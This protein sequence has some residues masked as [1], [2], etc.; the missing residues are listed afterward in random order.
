MK[1]YTTE[2]IRNVA[3]VGHS[4]SGKTTL[5]EAMMFER[6]HIERMGRTEDGNTQSDFLPEEIRRGISIS[7]AILP[8]ETGNVKIN[9]LDLP[10]FRD[11]VGEIKGGMRVSGGAVVVV[12]AMGGVEVGTEFALDYA[13]EMEVP[14]IFFVNKLDKDNSD[15]D[16]AMA[17][18]EAAVS[19]RFIVMSFPIGVA[20]GVNGVVDV[21][22][23]KAVYEKDGKVTFEDI[24]AGLRDRAKQY[25][26]AIADQAASDDDALAEK[27][28]S[29]E[30]LSHEEII[31]GL[32]KGF[33]ERHYFP[34][35]AGVASQAIG[36]QSLMDFIETGFPNPTE[37][38]G[39]VME[40]RETHDAHEEHFSDEGHTIIYVFKTLSDK[41][42]DHNFFK[43]VSGVVKKDVVLRNMTTNRDERLGHIYVQRGKSHEE[44]AELHAG[45]LGAVTKLADVHTNDTLVSAGCRDIV[46]PIRYPRPTVTMAIYPENRGDEDRMGEAARKLIGHDPTLSMERDVVTHETLV[47]GMGDMHLD[48]LVSRLVNNSKIPCHLQIPR[49]PYKE[50]VTARA[51]GAYRHKKQSGGRGQFGEVHLRVMPNQPGAGLDFRWVIVGGVIPGKYETA[52]RKGVEQAL[53]KGVVSGN[54]MVDVIVEIYDGKQ[55]DVD[56]SDMAFMIA[57]SMAFQKVA[58]DA[59]P[60]ILEPI[61]NVKITVPDQYL[62]DVMGDMSSRRGRILGQ[63]MSGGKLIVEA[64]A[65]LAELYEYS[66]NLRSM[67]QGRGIFEISFDHYERVPGD[68]Q[69]RLVEEYLKHRAEG[70]HQE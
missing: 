63:D 38:H 40:D 28:L 57:A 27:F 59:K 22:K 45:D 64:Q 69:T 41:F 29:G 51:E 33:V 48:V 42:G 24:P 1:V 7:A 52:I 58:A 23:M 34:V 46:V 26:E 18:L 14:V 56:S 13:Q 44:V 66:K 68:V 37:A 54:Q 55:H 47:R 8:I 35:F 5:A 2:Q 32:K 17:K 36:A 10:G 11:F 49:T 3:L 67:T 30:E 65:P 21:I 31:R 62:G 60:I 16:L 39:I 9:I 43:V 19:G 50:T 25:R 6:K 15:F 12:D 61:Y 4:G 53:A 70:D 20:G